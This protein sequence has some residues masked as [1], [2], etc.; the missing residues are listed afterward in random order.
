MKYLDEQIKVKVSGFDVRNSTTYPYTIKDISG[1]IIF[2]G[3]VFLYE[4]DSSVEINITDIV[5]NQKY[6]PTVLVDKDYTNNII[7]I[8]KT[9]TL[10]VFRKYL[11]NRYTVTITIDSV[12]YS[13][14]SE[15]VALIYRYPNRKEYLN[16]TIQ[17]P[18]DV[19]NRYN[20]LLQGKS[21]FLPHYP[22][23]ATTK[24]PFLLTFQKDARKT[25]IKTKVVGEINSLTAT[26]Q[27][28]PSV[29]VEVLIKPLTEYIYNTSYN[30]LF[31]YIVTLSGNMVKYND[32]SYYVSRDEITN[33][34]CAIMYYD[35]IRNMWTAL[36]I[37]DLPY[38]EEI[39]L[40]STINLSTQ[41]IINDINNYGIK[42]GFGYNN[43]N[44]DEYIIVKPTIPNNFLNMDIYVK[45][46]LSEIHDEFW[47]DTTFVYY[48]DDTLKETN[49]YLENKKVA[50]VDTGCYA[51]YYLMW[52]DRY[53]SFQ[54]QPFSG[55]VTFS[56]KFNREEMINYIGEGKYYNIN[57]E[58]N[59]KINTGWLND[60]VY[61]YYESIFTNP[62]L[63]LYDTK[64]DV[65]YVVQVTD[66]DY[67]EKTF[68]NQK[69]MFNL[70]LNVKEN[71]KQNILY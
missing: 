1:S 43:S 65:S 63:L 29:P 61:P 21:N 10:A 9:N 34:Q 27:L 52:Q 68:K 12:E 22:A 39:Q 26:Y 51:D 20:V 56:E 15:W 49:I 5:R 59:W 17:T 32:Y 6:I 57:I 33:L 47:V 55:T 24:Y 37:T 3:N 18:S 8:P 2:A 46:N 41:Q 35:S 31:E 45:T 62:Y 60:E 64:E 28:N 50:I 4:Q 44:L 11:F 69:K 54:S 38:D 71:K 25:E 40:T 30:P 16:T 53:G 70:T 19:L 48:I 42:I 67:T 36:N 14:N 13:N 66:N 23:K 58:P 7:D